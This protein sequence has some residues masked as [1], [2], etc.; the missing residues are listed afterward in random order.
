MKDSSSGNPVTD[1]QVQMSINMEL[2]N[3][4]TAQ[5]SIKGGNPTYIATFDKNRVF[6]MFGVWDIRLTIQSPA[7]APVMAVFPVTLRGT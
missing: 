7:S 4:G 3:M 1:A 2:M 6:S 5:A